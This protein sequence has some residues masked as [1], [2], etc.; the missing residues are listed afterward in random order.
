MKLLIVED[1]LRLLEDM[2]TFMSEQG[3]LCERAENHAQAEEKLSLYRYDAIL[4]D[5]TLPD[6]NGLRLL[7]L[8]KDLHPVTGVLIVSAKDSLDDKLKGLH[9]GAD[10]YITKPFHLE[11]LNARISALIRR[12]N[13]NGSTLITVD[14]VVIDTASKTVS[15][16]PEPVILTKTE[17][18]LLLYF[19]VNRNRVLSQQSIAE[20]LWGDHYDMAD[21]HSV[22]YVHTNNLR[23]KIHSATGRDY[24]K[25]V[26][27]MGYRWSTP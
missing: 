3:Y 20:H 15:V 4:L 5:I 17:Y 11:E 2:E 27:G 6:G 24:I 16:G 22:V 13:Y 12:T 14:D 7:E 23:K 1:E 26:Y 8:V 25:T 19:V 10:D 21:N 18:E 9:L